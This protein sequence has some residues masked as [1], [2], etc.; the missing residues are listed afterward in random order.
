MPFNQG[1]WNHLLNLLGR[2]S[3]PLSEYQLP[4]PPIG[5]DN[6]L[7]LSGYDTVADEGTDLAQQTKIN[8]VGDGVTATDS[9]GNTVVTISGVGAGSWPTFSG[10]LVDADTP[11]QLVSGKWYSVGSSDATIRLDLPLTPSVDDIVGCYASSQA[12]QITVYTSNS[13]EG[14]TIKDTGNSF[15][16]STA[17]AAFFQYDGNE[18]WIVIGV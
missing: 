17:T 12:Y 5:G 13:G 11:F 1:G 6:P 14:F 16:L 8:F 4:L 9:D 3:N 10:N 15:A 2:M 18:N 7:A